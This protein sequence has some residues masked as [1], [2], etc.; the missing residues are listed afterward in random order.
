MRM[1][2]G[3]FCF[4]LLLLHFTFELRGKLNVAHLFQKSYVKS[5]NAPKYSQR[6]PIGH[7]VVNSPFRE[8]N[9]PKGGAGA[10]F[11]NH[12]FRRWLQGCQIG[13]FNAKFEKIDIFLKHLAWKFGFGILFSEKS[14]FFPFD[15]R[16]GIF[17]KSDLATLVDCR[18]W[19]LSKPILRWHFINCDEKSLRTLGLRALF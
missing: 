17:A 16:F 5:A 12:C 18:G 15:T 14:F 10:Y 2:R 3:F 4:V 6:L 19:V 9:V 11:G 13:I 7:L 1:G 8:A